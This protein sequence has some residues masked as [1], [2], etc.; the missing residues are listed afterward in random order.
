[1]QL[2]LCGFIKPFNMDLKLKNKLFVVCGA[3]SGFGRAVAEALLAEG[4]EVVAIARSQD[5]MEAFAA[6]FPDRL[7]TIA[8]DITTD[9]AQ[10]KVLEACGTRPVSGAL[11]NAG[12]PP[13]MSFMESDLPDWDHAWQLLVRWKVAFV[14][15]LVPLMLNQSYG[16][17][18]FVES[19]SVK[20][21]VE[22]LVLSN[23]LRMA[24]VGFVK[25]LAQEVAARNITLNVLAPG[26]H[27]TAAMQRLFVKKAGIEGISTEEAR[28]RFEKAIPVGAMG[29]ASEMANLALWLLSPLS[30]FVTGQ[31]ISHDGGIVRGVF[32]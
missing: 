19:V 23:S 32:G 17:I 9:A 18:V 12:G 10:Q 24:V 26:Y 16:R 31:T 25:T 3:G 8:G 29:E 30:R 15:K 13:A 5:V 20:Q 11:I 21:P 2:Y 6:Q 22:N 14:K 28:S 27:N 1:M 4:A 7:T